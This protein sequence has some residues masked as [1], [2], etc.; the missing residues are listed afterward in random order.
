MMQV[1]FSDVTEGVRIFLEPIIEKL[2]TQEIFTGEWS[3][4]EKS[5][6]H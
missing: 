3:S 2:R 4:Y 1:D 6:R 5:W